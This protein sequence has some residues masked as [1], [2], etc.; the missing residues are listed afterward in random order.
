MPAMDTKAIMHVEPSLAVP[1]IEG[2]PFAPAL[3]IAAISTSVSGATEVISSVFR[4]KD[5]GRTEVGNTQ[6]LLEM[7][8]SRTCTGGSE[9]LDESVV[10]GRDWTHVTIAR[11]LERTQVRM[12]WAGVAP[13]RFAAARTGSST[14]PPGYRVMGLTKS[15]QRIDGTKATADVRKGAISFEKDVVFGSELDQFF[16]LVVVI[17]VKGYLLQVKPAPLSSHK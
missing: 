4:S 11:P 5:V 2:G 15:S 6:V 13:R 12:T 8:F 14:G 10:S 17:W 1:K 16:V 7:F 3:S 9:K